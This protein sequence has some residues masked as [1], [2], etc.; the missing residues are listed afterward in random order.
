TKSRARPS[1]GTSGSLSGAGSAEGRARDFVPASK[2]PT[3]GLSAVELERYARLRDWRN[4]EAAR[5]GVS[6]FIVMSNA[7]IALLARENPS[8]P[9]ALA[10]VKGMGPERIRKYAS[11]ILA[12]LAGGNE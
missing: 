11:G 8:D 6:R 10:N 4:D 5:Q 9:D 3:T 12:A 1:A 2:D 7:L